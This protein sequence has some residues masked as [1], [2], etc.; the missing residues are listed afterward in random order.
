MINLLNPYTASRCPSSLCEL[1]K[2]CVREIVIGFT[3]FLQL[4]QIFSKDTTIL[5]RHQRN[6]IIKFIK[7]RFPIFISQI[8][9]LMQNILIIFKSLQKDEKE[10]LVIYLVPE[11][12]SCTY[13]KYCNLH[14][15]FQII[16]ALDVTTD[17][18]ADLKD[19]LESICKDLKKSNTKFDGSENDENFESTN[20]IMD[21]VNASSNS[22]DKDLKVFLHGCE[23][24]KLHDIYGKISSLL[25]IIQHKQ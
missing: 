22:I 10:E 25:E 14:I 15:F 5:N 6:E 7:T 3:L 8:Q 19:S 1:F 13:F 4:S 11:V 12:C 16:F 23:V 24:K 17:L 18:L 21:N 2:Q 9:Q 20:D